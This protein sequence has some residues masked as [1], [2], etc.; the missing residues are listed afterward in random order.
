VHTARWDGRDENGQ[1]LASGVYLA[2]LVAGGRA[3][4]LKLVLLK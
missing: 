2:R 3:A 4:E 1:A